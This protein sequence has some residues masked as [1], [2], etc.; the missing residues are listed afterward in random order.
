MAHKITPKLN[1]SEL[2]PEQLTSTEFRRGFLD[3]RMVKWLQTDLELVAG[4]LLPF[5][6]CLTHIRHLE[7]LPMREVAA[8][9]FDSN[10]TVPG[11]L[12]FQAIL[13]GSGAK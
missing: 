7:N 1:S 8:R 2:T 11:P 6:E 13:K 9:F 12:R 10:K 4:K 5:E 3:G